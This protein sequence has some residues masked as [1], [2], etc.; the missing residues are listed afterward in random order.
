[1]L[2]GDAGMLVPNGTCVE[3]SGMMAQNDERDEADVSVGTRDVQLVV[4][5][6]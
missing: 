6:K 4:C 5:R 3:E 2:E 1:M